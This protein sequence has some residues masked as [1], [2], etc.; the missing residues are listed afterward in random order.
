MTKEQEAEIALDLLKW[1]LDEHEAGECCCCDLT[2]GGFGL[3]FAGQWSDGC[4][5]DAKVI[6]TLAPERKTVI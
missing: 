3:C 6:E 1:L 5:S 2:D 4:I